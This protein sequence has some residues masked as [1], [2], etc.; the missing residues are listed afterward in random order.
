MRGCTSTYYL[1]SLEQALTSTIGTCRLATSR[2]LPSLAKA[3]MLT[4]N[5]YSRGAHALKL[6]CTWKTFGDEKEIVSSEGSVKGDFLLNSSIRGRASYLSNS[7]SRAAMD[8]YFTNHVVSA[9][10]R[11]S[12]SESGK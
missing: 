1:H 6:L 10:T 3:T 9:T 5:F 4:T 12:A 2:Y 7:R 8:P 11:L